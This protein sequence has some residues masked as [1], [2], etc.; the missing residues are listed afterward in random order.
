MNSSLITALFLLCG[1][2]LADEY[3]YDHMATTGLTNRV[4]DSK[5][6]ETTI[7]FSK[8]SNAEA[9]FFL[10]SLLDLGISGTKKNQRWN[11]VA[12]EQA[13]ILK[14]KL[15]TKVLRTSSAPNTAAAE[16]YQE[17]TLEK[18]TVHFP[19]MLVKPGKIFDTGYLETHFSFATL[20]PAGLSFKGK[21]ID[22]SKHSAT[23]KTTENDNQ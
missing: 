18:V 13:I 17:F 9:L 8:E 20:L 3:R 7:V 19:L 5:G 15:E 4:F 6:I 1:F 14:G 10:Y 21:K 2:A 11:G 12:Y 23:A 16:D 22:L